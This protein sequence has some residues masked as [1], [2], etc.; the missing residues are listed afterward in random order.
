MRYGFGHIY[1][2]LGTIRVMHFY[3]S[4]GAL[5]LLRSRLDNNIQ[6]ELFHRAILATVSPGDVVLCMSPGTGI[7]SLFAAQGGA[8]RVYVIEPAV[9]IEVAK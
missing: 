8:S 9:R 7:L 1:R 4:M 3:N 6:L 5:G 2:R